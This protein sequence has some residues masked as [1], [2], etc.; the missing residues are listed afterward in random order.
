VCGFDELEAIANPAAREPGPQV[1]FVRCLTV[2]KVDS[3]VISSFTADRGS[4]LRGCVANMSLTH[5]RE[6]A[7][8]VVSPV[9]VAMKKVPAGGRI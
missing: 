1:I 9:S 6:V 4:H 8:S 2:E 7:S 5:P 3:M